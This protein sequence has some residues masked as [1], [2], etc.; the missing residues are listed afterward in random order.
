MDDAKTISR[1]SKTAEKRNSASTAQAVGKFCQMDEQT[2][3]CRG[4]PQGQEKVCTSYDVANTFLKM[5]FPKRLHE[6]EEVQDCDNLKMER[7][8]YKSLSYIVKKFELRL[9]DFRN[10]PFPYNI[11]ESLKALRL[12]LKNNKEDW[13]DVRLIHANNSTYFAREERYC[14]GMTLYYIPVIPLYTLL[15]SKKTATVGNLLLSVYAYLY[16]VLHIPYYRG[17][18]CYLNNTYQVL[19]DWI[20]D[21]EADDET[22]EDNNEAKSIGDYMKEKI[23]DPV[24]LRY[25]GRRI[26][27]FKVKNNFDALSFRVAKEF[28]DLFQNYPDVPIYRKFYPINLR[29]ET[30]Y[31][32]R[33][34]MLDD[35][36]SF[37]ASIKGNL[38]DSLIETVN[39]DLQEYG[40]IDEPTIFIPYDGRKIEENNFDFERAVFRSLDNL[41]RL[42]QESIY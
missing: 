20:V 39:S 6:I 9:Q 34:V 32:E 18:D 2:K 12:G 23:K 22:I 11:S 3:G 4:N 42:W 28:Y 17:N 24:N 7:E 35:Y 29:E 26:K 36:I 30:E 19:N 31:S 16:H 8:F 10:I 38:F 37:C 13:K 40:E 21:D 25:F 27:N 1:N 41:I 14:T 15:Q 33:T 5:Q